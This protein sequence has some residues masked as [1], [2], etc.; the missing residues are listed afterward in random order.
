[1]KSLSAQANGLDQAVLEL[2]DSAQVSLNIALYHLSLPAVVQALE[3]ACH[4]GVTIRLIL[5]AEQPRP[6]GLSNCI[7]LK[8]DR[9]PRSMHHKFMIVDQHTVWIGSANWTES[10]F[11]FD[12]NNAIAIQSEAV[13]QAFLSEFHEMYSEDRFGSAKRDTNEERFRVHGSW[14][15]AYFSPSDRPRVR[16]LELLRS[17]KQ[18]I[19]LAVYAFTDQELY[20]ALLAARSRGVRVEA[21]WDS[22]S[23]EECFSSKVDEMLKSGVGILDANPG[24]LHHKYAILDDSV[25]IT[26]SA[27]WSKSGMESNDE[28][29][30]IVH[31]EQ[32]AQQYKQNF[33][34]FA[35]DA[36]TYE[37]DTHQPPRVEMRQFHVTRDAVLL[38]WRPHALRS[39][40]GYEICR[41]SDAQVQEC[42][43]IYEAPGW[44]WYFLDREVASGQQYF[45]RVRSHTNN[46]W[47]DYSNTY[48]ARVQGEIPILT[49]EQV[50]QD[51][52]RYE[53]QTVTVR[54]RVTNQP[55]PK[56]SEGHI[57]LNAGQDYKTD[58]TAF[59]PACSLERFSGSGIDL[60]GLQGQFIEVTGELEEFHGPEI[61]V[62][63]PW[64]IRLLR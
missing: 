12:A 26:G 33:E 52:Q 7:Q 28:S 29:I 37:V 5:E 2:I 25:V 47:T 32:I 54:F 39:V 6:Q 63:A 10:S 64:Q 8:R 48:P 3:R 24:L 27:N 61:I 58:F 23:L 14:L 45:Y 19:R 53:G 16:L 35:R 1:M 13:A 9:N 51:S 62:E 43:R 60:F 17:A 44:A 4:R 21:V 57:Y 40:D 49:A 56:G 36:Q 46:Q 59:V 42:E 55:E 31:D 11:Y 20:E 30:L 15:E 34:Q 38:Q 22:L 41:G 18:S 50:E